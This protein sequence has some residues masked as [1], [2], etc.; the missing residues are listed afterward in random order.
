[1]KSERTI[2]RSVL[3]V[4]VF[5]ALL[6]AG[7]ANAIQIDSPLPTD[8]SIPPSP[9]VSLGNQPVI[10]YT[11]MTSWDH[12]GW[13][14]AQKAPMRAAIK[15]IDGVLPNN[16][17][18]ETGDFTVRWGG[19]D[20]FKDWRSRDEHGDLDLTGPYSAAGWDLSTP[21]AVAYKHNNGPWD[22]NTYPN[23]EIYVNSSYPWHMDPGT[24]P[25]ADKYDLVSVLMH[26]II[27]M[28]AC[29][30]HAVHPDEVMYATI[31]M[32]ERKSI[33]DSDL[34]I[35]MSANYTVPEP[36]T[37]GLLALGGLVL[38]RRRRK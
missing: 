14:E 2:V 27:H 34:Q 21:L 23:N 35:L 25:P 16:T 29:D 15:T 20:F 28:L 10:T 17:F 3:I 33:Q 9:W 24:P 5:S 18:T 6:F 11:F 19:A 26:E 31:G 32:G 1:M 4:L 7:A 12:V 30:T 37:A 36:F 38:V 22:A 8:P 13:T